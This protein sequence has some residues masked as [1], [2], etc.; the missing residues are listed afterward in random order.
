LFSLFAKTWIFDKSSVTGGMK[1]SKPHGHI[2]C[3]TRLLHFDSEFDATLLPLKFALEKN[4]A[5]NLK[6]ITKGD[7]SSRL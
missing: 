6:E 4:I 3:I 1:V 2:D 7:P 5:K